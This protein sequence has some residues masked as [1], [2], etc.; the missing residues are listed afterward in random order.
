MD[1][2]TGNYF[3]LLIYM[4]CLTD[5]YLDC[6]SLFSNWF[7]Q[8]FFLF[9][10]FSKDTTLW[11]HLQTM[12]YPKV[13][14]FS[15]SLLLKIWYNLL[16]ILG[17]S[18]LVFSG[19]GDAHLFHTALWLLKLLLVLKKPPPPCN[20]FLKNILKCSQHKAQGQLNR[21]DKLQ[22][23]AMEILLF[24]SYFYMTQKSSFTL[25]VYPIWKSIARSLKRADGILQPATWNLQPKPSKYNSSMITFP[26]LETEIKK[27]ASATLRLKPMTCMRCLLFYLWS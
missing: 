8:M 14:A 26:L 6:S 17:V 19:L 25:E 16:L 15:F 24:K 12:Y 3:Q 20:I 27:Q 13:I 1:E 4:L 2:F 18:N 5:I 21:Q 9:F 7:L 10:Y 22:N 11:F 23:A